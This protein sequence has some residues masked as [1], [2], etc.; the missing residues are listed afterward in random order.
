MI[1]T[2]NFRTQI[3]SAAGTDSIQVELSDKAVFNELIDTVKNKA[4]NNLNE[5]LFTDDHNL[6]RSLLF[7]LNNT[8]QIRQEDNITLN[9]GDVITIIAPISGG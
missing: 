5:M 4:L 8:H 9:N 6:S 3:R 1:I 2:I 7:T